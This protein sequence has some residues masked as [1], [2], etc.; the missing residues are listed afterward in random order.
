[1]PP[2]KSVYFWILSWDSALKIVTG[3]NCYVCKVCLFD[4]LSRITLCGLLLWIVLSVVMIM[5]QYSLWL[6]YYSTI[7]AHIC[8][9][10]LWS[11][12]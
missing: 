11:L 5:S 2:F 9:V 4:G 8:N 1:M 3:G 10:Y 6:G 12:L 7:V